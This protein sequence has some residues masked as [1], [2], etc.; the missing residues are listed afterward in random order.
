MWSIYLLNVL[1]ST[2]KIRTKSSLYV[3]I[4]ID[5]KVLKA[6]IDTNTFHHFNS[7]EEAQRLGIKVTGGGDS[8]KTTNL[9][10]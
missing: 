1:S 7:I 4:T 10:A 6:M 5:E 8:I 3:E 2:P 9:A